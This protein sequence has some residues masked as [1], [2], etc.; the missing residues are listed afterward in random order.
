[1]N[2]H[3]ISLSLLMLL[4][5]ATVWA[6]DVGISQAEILEFDGNAY[7]FIVRF[8]DST[9][10][11]HA[12]PRLPPFC[13]YSSTPGARLP[14]GMQTSGSKVWAFS[15]DRQLT[16]NDHIVLPW[17][18]DGVSVS[19][20]WRDGASATRLFGSQNGV[21]RVELNE[22]QAEPG[23]AADAAG[24]YLLLGVEH[25]LDGFD[26]LLFVLGLLLIVSGP[27]LRWLM[28]IRTVTAFTLAHSLTLGLATFGLIK[29]PG[30]PVEA[31][32]ALSIVF[33]AVEVLRGWQGLLSLTH[34]Q[35]W[36]VAFG[37]GLLHGLGFAGAL[38]DV[39]LP[40]AKVPVA[41]LSFNVGVEIGQLLFVGV[42]LAGHALLTR[43]PMRWPACTAYAPVYLMGT[44]GAYWVVERVVNMAAPG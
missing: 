27:P 5:A 35:P 14:G 16:A 26:H 11:A 15:C 19:A 22:L 7:E 25:I 31:A 32:I 44:V 29:L 13:S 12:T 8:G 3:G 20:R 23:S 21:I 40:R 39:G 6:H 17:R 38:A 10:F 4:C 43:L 33:L 34:R 42:V 37:F 1:M 36:L 28:L 41:L 18:R 9:A 30:R 2:A 24:R